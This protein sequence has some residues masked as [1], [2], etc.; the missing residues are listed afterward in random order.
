MFDALPAVRVC[1]LS[2]IGKEH[3]PPCATKKLALRQQSLFS[4]HA[5]WHFANG[6]PSSVLEP[7]SYGTLTRF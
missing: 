6:R 1:L 3:P 4:R 2:L 5:K 7:G